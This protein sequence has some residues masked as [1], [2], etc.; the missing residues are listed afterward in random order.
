MN[1][2][3]SWALKSPKTLWIENHSKNH[4]QIIQ[5]RL[6]RR[7]LDDDQMFYLMKTWLKIIGE[8]NLHFNLLFTVRIGEIVIANRLTTR[9]T[10]RLDSSKVQNLNQSH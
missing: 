1:F 9:L 8:E 3:L 5:M 10:S 6:Y 7:A 4:R 2:I